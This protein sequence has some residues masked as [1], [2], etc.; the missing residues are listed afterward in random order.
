MAVC[1]VC[2]R[3][4]EEDPL[5]FADWFWSHRLEDAIWLAEQNRL[6]LIKRNLSD[7]LELEAKLREHL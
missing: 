3:W 1:S 7:Y 6:G 2:H 4:A 5:A